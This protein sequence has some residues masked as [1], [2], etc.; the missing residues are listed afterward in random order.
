MDL[1]RDIST[2][3]PIALAALRRGAT[4]AISVSGGK[5]SQAMLYRLVE[6]RKAL[7]WTGPSHAV[8]ADLGRAEWPQTLAHVEAMCRSRHV[9]LSVVRRDRGDLVARIEERLNTVSTLDGTRTAKPFWPSAAQ[10][11]CT[12]DL[13]R[14]PIQKW[15]RTLGKDVV[16]VSA[17]GMRSEESSRRAKMEPLSVNKALTS[18]HLRGVTS[19]NSRGY[20]PS[21]ALSAWQSEGGRL[22]LDWLALF[23]WSEEQV[24]AALVPGGIREL[25]ARQKLYRDGDEAAAL[26]GWLAHPAYVWGNRRLSCALCVLACRG[27]LVNGIRHNPQLA[28]RYVLLERASGYSFKQGQSLEALAAEEMIRLPILEP[29]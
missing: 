20:T 3:D 18:K 15:L 6:M 25:R 29:A 24:W 9:P 4:L 12:S 7:D 21:E 13:K 1:F 10:R 5:D 28:A 17:Q 27:D 22:V 2:Y 16:I 8:H 23:D 19:S 26:H 14:G 11:Y